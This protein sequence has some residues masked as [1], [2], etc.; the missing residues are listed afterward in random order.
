MIEEVLRDPLASLSEGQA[1][2]LKELIEKVQFVRKLLTERDALARAA[3]ETARSAAIQRLLEDTPWRRVLF[4]LPKLEGADEAAAMA[5]DA[6][7]QTALVAAIVEAVDTGTLASLGSTFVAELRKVPAAQAAA[8]VIVRD[9]GP[10]PAAQLAFLATPRLLQGRGGIEQMLAGANAI[11]NGLRSPG[12]AE[13]A[14]LPA[15]LASVVEG[16]ASL[17][18][19]NL[20]L[21]D[22]RTVC[23]KLAVI[24]KTLAGLAGLLVPVEDGAAS[25]ANALANLG[26][27]L[28]AI[29][30]GPPP[31]GS[32]AVLPPLPDAKGGIRLDEVPAFAKFLATELGAVA[33]VF[34][35]QGEAELVLARQALARHGAALA[36][37]LARVQRE[38]AS[39]QQWTTTPPV[40]CETPGPILSMLATI[41]TQRDAALDAMLALLDEALK[42][43]DQLVNLAN[44]LKTVDLPAATLAQRQKLLQDACEAWRATMLGALRL[45]QAVTLLALQV[46]SAGAK[47]GLTTDRAQ[48]LT[49]VVGGL[50]AIAAALP[51]GT[52]KTA[53]QGARAGLTGAADALKT[54]QGELLTRANELRRLPLSTADAALQAAATSASGLRALGASVQGRVREQ[55]ETALVDVLLRLGASMAVPLSDG[56]VKALEPL[57]DLLDKA[58]ATVHE[59]REKL[60]AAIAQEQP[61]AGL[62]SAWLSVI[63][64]RLGAALFTVPCGPD[65][66]QGCGEDRLTYEAGLA[67][68]AYAAAAAGDLAASI[69]SV[70]LLAEVWQKPG[71]AVVAFARQLTAIDAEFARTV[72]LSA[73][74]LKAIRREIESR[75]R[76]LIPSRVTLSYDLDNELGSYPSG[77][78]IFRSDKTRLSVHAKTV[79]DLMPDSQNH[80]KPPQ[81]SV[82]GEMGPFAIALLGQRFDVVTLFFDGLSFKSGTGISSDFQVRFRD[83]KMGEK[84][85]FLEQL[86]S[87]L[88]PK[89]D[90]FYIKLLRGVPG[91]EAGYGINLGVIGIGTLSFSNVILAAAVRL[92]FDNSEARFLISIGRSDA[93]FLISSTIFGGGGYLALIASSQ[94]FVG[95]EASFDYGGVVAFGFGPLQGIGRVTMGVYLRKEGAQTS[96]GATFFAGGAAHIACFGLS[97]ALMVRMVQDNGGPMYGSA[98]YTF[99]FS[100]GITDIDFEVQVVKDE[101]RTIGGGGQSADA[102]PLGPS[103]TML[104]DASDRTVLSDAGPVTRISSKGAPAKPS[105]KGPEPAKSLPPALSKARVTGTTQDRNWAEY[106]NY[107]DLNVVPAERWSPL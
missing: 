61:G 7:C 33:L 1:K 106:R 94:G 71:P 92:P 73:I 62:L 22:V 20:A 79:I 45:Y 80:F 37:A 52:A 54:I 56:L 78:P 42:V 6:A 48:H 98:T 36:F 14:A 67:K 77:D 19:R 21:P 91:I 3:F 5:L 55:V 17:L 85:R 93:P 107:F 28:R 100:L 29:A 51:D 25:S 13:L 43:P 97:T 72:L 12:T 27:E 11:R 105:A 39:A 8:E 18:G 30:A 89:G 35:L 58:Y 82:T 57:L 87:Y 68:A 103:L 88:S 46:N 16:V 64:S 40:G 10:D 23:D 81:F 31:A 75:I 60:K 9:A 76:D 53:V 47:E 86:Q 84:A 2:T 70:R 4:S 66:P 34:Q 15:N 41:T 90:G 44:S 63:R 102:V 96:L 49:G 69:G 74:D 104:A 32:R 26:V 101:G 99:S 83:V 38:V 65:G 24:P 59:Q 95:F 50:D